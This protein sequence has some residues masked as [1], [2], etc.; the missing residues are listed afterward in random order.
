MYAV[1]FRGLGS[2]AAATLAK[3]CSGD[4]TLLPALQ[5]S[6]QA[7]ELAALVQTA[8]LGTQ[9]K[10]IEVR[11]PLFPSLWR[12]PKSNGWHTSIYDSCEWYQH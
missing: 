8:A 5:A 11:P 10:D 2:K 9:A 7:E 1:S 4:Q 3:L 6:L 12:I